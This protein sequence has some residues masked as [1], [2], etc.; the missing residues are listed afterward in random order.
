MT[1]LVLNF[2]SLFWNLCAFPKISDHVQKGVKK[3]EYENITV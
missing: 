3:N 2:Q 1:A